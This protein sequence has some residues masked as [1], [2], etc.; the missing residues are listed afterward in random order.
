MSKA[1]ENFFEGCNEVVLAMEIALARL[2]KSG[3]ISKSVILADIG[4]RHN[5]MAGSILPFVAKQ[6]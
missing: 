2:K 5:G 1:E 4:N 3:G 6:I